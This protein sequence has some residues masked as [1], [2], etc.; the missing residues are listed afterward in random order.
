M[1]TRLH[2]LQIAAPFGVRST[3]DNHNPTDVIAT[4][5]A[6]GLGLP[7]RDYYFSTEKRFVEARETYREHVARMFELTGSSPAAAKQ[8]AQTIFDFESRLAKAH[9]TNVELRDPKLT[10]HQDHRRRAAEDTPHFDWKVYL[11]KTGHRPGRLNVE[12]LKFMARPRASVARRDR[13][14][15]AYLR[16]NVINSAAAS[17]PNRS[18]NRTSRSTTNYSSGRRR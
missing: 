10:D 11:D 13:G 6:A 5:F 9:L 4:I 3:P 17:S 12:Q 14:M 15:E 2:D 16:W 18:S 8:A 1:I 7:D